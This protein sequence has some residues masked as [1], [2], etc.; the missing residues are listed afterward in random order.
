MTD[1]EIRAEIAAECRALEEVALK[2]LGDADV[3]E[4]IYVAAL[5]QRCLVA[6]GAYEPRP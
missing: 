1:D 6:A 3:A 5:A 4:R 2:A